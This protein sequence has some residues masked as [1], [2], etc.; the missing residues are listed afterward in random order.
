[1]EGDDDNVCSRGGFCRGRIFGGRPQA[2]GQGL[3]GTQICR[4]LEQFS[5]TIE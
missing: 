1:M 3:S 4:F 2:F 5:V